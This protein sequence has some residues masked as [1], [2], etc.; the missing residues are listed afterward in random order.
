[1]SV[2]FQVSFQNDKASEVSFPKCRFENGVAARAYGS[3]KRQTTHAHNASPK[4]T[5]DWALSRRAHM[6]RLGF[7]SIY[8]PLKSNPTKRTT[9]GAVN[10]VSTDAVSALR[11]RRFPPVGAPIRVADL[12]QNCCPIVLTIRRLPSARSSLAA[13]VAFPAVASP[14]SS[15]SVARRGPAAPPSIVA[16]EQN[17]VAN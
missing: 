14:H 16:L 1:M 3:P 11:A 7:S 15:V 4:E 13:V 10:E 8:W 12:R 17:H 9:A 2:S 5:T 6:C